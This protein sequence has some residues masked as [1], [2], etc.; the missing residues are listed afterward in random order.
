MS[1]VSAFGMGDDF[2]AVRVRMTVWETSGSVSS[3]RSKAAAA[4]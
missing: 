1:S 4:A 3:V 2:I